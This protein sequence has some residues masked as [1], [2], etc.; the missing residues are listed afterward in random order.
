M[1]Q[2]RF[3]L[4]TLCLGILALSGCSNTFDGMGRDMKGAGEWLED[5]F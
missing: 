4:M 2:S 1:T 5:T 3:L